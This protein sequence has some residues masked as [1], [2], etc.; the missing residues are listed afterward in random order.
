MSE[1]H[2]LIL[3]DLW[4]QERVTLTT[5]KMD[6]IESMIESAQ[7]Q[8]EYMRQLTLAMQLATHL[9]H[10]TSLSSLQSYMSNR[11]QPAA[12][13]IQPSSTSSSS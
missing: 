4:A 3:R 6:Q 7:Q 11:F 9:D 8:Q 12:V 13:V 1:C 2:Q 10:S 5:D